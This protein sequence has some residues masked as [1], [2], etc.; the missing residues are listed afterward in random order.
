MGGVLFCTCKYDGGLPARAQPRPKNISKSQ[1]KQTQRCL[2]SR[3]STSV[4]LDTSSLT[5]PPSE[6]R[7]E[8]LDVDV[9]A[10]ARRS[11]E[12]RLARP[13]RCRLQHLSSSQK[14]WREPID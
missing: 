14:I 5:A 7:G 11:R 3:R 9:A 1:L 12:K 2:A 4:T 13:S 6:E 8:Q 10:R